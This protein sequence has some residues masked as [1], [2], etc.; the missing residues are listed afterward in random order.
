MT[1][2]SSRTASLSCLVATARSKAGGRPP[3]RPPLPS[4]IQLH[5]VIESGQPHQPGNTS[6][7]SRE[8]TLADLAGAARPGPD[9]CGQA[10]AFQLGVAR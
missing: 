3:V 9:E 6:Q 5:R 8:W 1:V 2:A 7:L 10:L 4:Q